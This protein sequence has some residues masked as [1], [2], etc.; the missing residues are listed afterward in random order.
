MLDKDKKFII[1]AHH[2]IILDAIET[3]VHDKVLLMNLT[4]FRVP[5][6]LF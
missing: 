3:T 5:N 2:Q 1:F 4:L 6:L